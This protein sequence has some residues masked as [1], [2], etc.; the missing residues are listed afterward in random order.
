MSA[1]A[2]CG[3]TVLPPCTLCA[4]CDAQLGDDAAPKGGSALASALKPS[5]GKYEPPVDA[6]VVRCRKCAK[7]HEPGVWRCFKCNTSLRP[8]WLGIM[9]VAGPISIVLLSLPLIDEF[10]H[11]RPALLSLLLN[12][13]AFVVLIALR[14]GRYWAWFAIQALWAVNV[15]VL[16]AT[17]FRAKIPAGLFLL[18]AAVL[19]ANW[20]Y[21]HRPAVRAFCSVGRRRT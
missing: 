14:F 21:I 2:C 5:P 20:I 3:A 13:A 8:I 12:V 7:A 6:L 1:C 15:V 17:P 10:R 16:I 18:F 11:H 19:V 4:T 9:T